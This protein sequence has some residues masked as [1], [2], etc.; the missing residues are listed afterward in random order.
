MVVVTVMNRIVDDQIK[1]LTAAHEQHRTISQ[2]VALA[3]RTDAAERANQ[4]LKAALDASRKAMA[5]GMNE[6]GSKIIAIIREETENML[7]EMAAQAA[8]MGRA[9]T[10]YKRFTSW[11]L[12]A[13]CIVLAA[14]LVITALR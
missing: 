6:G 13:N 5:K 9:A 11:M 10:A 8:S 12:I 4:I 2:E 7:A 1:A 14:A 3:W